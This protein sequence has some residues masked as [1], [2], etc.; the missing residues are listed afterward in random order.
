MSCTPDAIGPLL[1]GTGTL[2][3]DGV[4]VGNV[5]IADVAGEGENQTI[6]YPTQTA[7]GDNSQAQLGFQQRV[8]IEATCDWATLEN[9]ELLLKE[10][11]ANIAGGARIPFTTVREE[12]LHLVEFTHDMQLC[13]DEQCSALVIVLRRAFVELPW[14]LPFRRDSFTEFVLRF[15]ALPHAGF[16]ASPFGYMERLCTGGAS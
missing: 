1:L 6:F 16:P 13:G 2:L 7:P 8:I 9:L 10:Q 5:A 15:I 11:G 14:T 4:D 12:G 3:V